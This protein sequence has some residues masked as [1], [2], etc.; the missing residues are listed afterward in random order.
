M[1]LGSF[2]WTRIVRLGYTIPRMKPTLFIGILIPRMG[3]IFLD[4]PWVCKVL[5]HKGIIL[6]LF[7]TF[8][9]VFYN[10]ITVI[11]H[12]LV[13]VSVLYPAVRLVGKL[14]VSHHSFLSKSSSVGLTLLHIYVPYG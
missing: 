11:K 9:E 7:Y 4:Y 2:L 1:G 6:S 5:P 10:T 14:T 8:C 3:Y 13:I 12:L